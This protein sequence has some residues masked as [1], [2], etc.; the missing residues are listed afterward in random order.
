MSGGDMSREGGR[1]GIIMPYFSDVYRHSGATT[2]TQ[3]SCL[4]VMLLED[5]ERRV[6]TRFLSLQ[7]PPEVANFVGER[8]QTRSSS[9]TPIF[10]LRLPHVPSEIAA[11]T[12]DFPASKVAQL[13][14][15]RILSLVVEEF[16][17]RSTN[18][19]MGRTTFQEL[20]QMSARRHL[21]LLGIRTRLRK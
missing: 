20:L 21:G 3:K 1:E 15:R 10:A 9:V 12:S 2:S 4:T 6:G 11:P 16:G 19:Q 7:T 13:T 18:Q 8:T 14:V 5:V 17:Y